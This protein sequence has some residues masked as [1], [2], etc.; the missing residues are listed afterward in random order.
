[1]NGDP[2]SSPVAFFA[3]EMKRQR[4]INSKTQ[5]QL[6]DEAGHAPATIAAI[7]TCRLPSEDLAR[8]IDKSFGAGGLFERLQ[9]LVERASVLPWFRDL[10]ETEKQATRQ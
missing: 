7:E 3:A 1:M 8:R 5:E 9:G 6:A 10:V 2:S 4:A